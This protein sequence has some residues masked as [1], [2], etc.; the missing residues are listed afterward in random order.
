MIG[1]MNVGSALRAVSLATLVA[2]F[3]PTLAT[4]QQGQEIPETPRQSAAKTGA[5]QGK[6][7]AWVKVCTK[8]Q[9]TK[10]K[11]VCLIKYEGLD[12]KSGTFCSPLPCASLKV[13]I[14]GT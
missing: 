7:S 5:A 12:P 3:G 11:Q 14:S 1:S 6:Y 4:G 9:D 2:G 8:S 13:R 10:N